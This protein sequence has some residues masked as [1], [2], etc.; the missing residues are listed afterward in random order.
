MADPVDD[1][2]YNP[3]DLDQLAAETGDERFAD[4]ADAIRELSVDDDRDS[5]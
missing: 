5:V 1:I 3:D 2:K 4:V